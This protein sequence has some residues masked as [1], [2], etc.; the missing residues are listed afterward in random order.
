[1]NAWAPW[2]VEK[3]NTWGS[4]RETAQFLPLLTLILCLGLVADISFKNLRFQVTWEL[5]ILGE[6]CVANLEEQ[7][8]T[9]VKVDFKNNSGGNVRANVM[10]T[11]NFILQV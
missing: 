4:Q 8:P 3:A 2:L 5:S 10:L 7:V 1:M 6:K 9:G 11:A